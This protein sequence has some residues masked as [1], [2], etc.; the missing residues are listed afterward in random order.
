MLAGT[1]APATTRTVP[2]SVNAPLPS[3]MLA[4]LSVR[5]D[6]Q[7]PEGSDRG[8]RRRRRRPAAA[9]V[10]S[11]GA[12]VADGEVCRWS[13][14]SSVPSMA[15]VPMPVALLPTMALVLLIAPPLRMLTVPVPELPTK[16]VTELVHFEL[17]P[18]T[19]TLP[20]EPGQRRP[21]RGYGDGRP[22]GDRHDSVAA[23]PQ[24]DA[25]GIGPAR[26][27]PSTVA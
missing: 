27:E 6:C 2:L 19:V 13:R 16:R 10:Q 8:G 1:S 12:G 9:D 3:L 18:E 5:V 25:A 11:P 22:V 20:V 14:S 7:K 23:L 21:R 17:A 15:T 4:N 24:V 26:V